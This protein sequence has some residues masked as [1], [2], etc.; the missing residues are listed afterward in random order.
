[1]RLTNGKIRLLSLLAVSLSLGLAYAQN[2]GDTKHDTGDSGKKGDD[3]YALVVGISNYRQGDKTEWIDLHGAEDA[4]AMQAALQKRGFLPSH[5]CMLV[6]E[7]ATRSKIEQSFRDCLIRRAHKDATLVFYFSG[8]GDQLLD[9]NG[10]EADGL[11]EALVPYD[12]NATPD[13]KNFLR[14]DR[15]AALL[16]EARRQM[17]NERGELQGDIAVFLDSCFAGSATRGGKDSPIIYRGRVPSSALPQTTAVG[18]VAKSSTDVLPGDDNSAQIVVLS[19]AQSSESAVEMR[20]EENK[21]QRGLFTYALTEALSRIRNPASGPLTYRA[22]FEE[23][24]AHVTQT[25]PA[26]HPQ[27]EGSPQAISRALFSQKVVYEG[28]Y[29]P[30]LSIDAATRTAVLPV[31]TLHGATLGSHYALFPAGKVVAAV[32]TCAKQAG[33]VGEATLSAVGAAR[34]TAQLTGDA[35]LADLVAG[36]AVEI[37]HSHPAVPALKVWLTPGAQV[38]AGLFSADPQAVVVL[39]SEADHDVRIEVREGALWAIKTGAPMAQLRTRAALADADTV[40]YRKPLPTAA[41]SRAPLPVALFGELDEALRAHWAYR[42]LSALSQSDDTLSVA[43]QLVRVQTPLQTKAAPDARPFDLNEEVAIEAQNQSPNPVYISIIELTPQ[44]DINVLYPDT[45]RQRGITN[46]TLP[47]GG[48]WKRLDARIRLNPPGQLLWKV[49]ITQQPADFSVIAHQRVLKGQSP[50][51]ALSKLPVAVQPLGQLI[52]NA[53]LR[54]R[55]QNVWSAPDSWA[56][57]DY[58]VSVAGAAPAVKKTP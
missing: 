39:G 55:S 37:L 15:L 24:R 21:P 12:W 48:T 3:Q 28:R 11:D 16:E 27:L 4:V 40:L 33:C 25:F 18:P 41:G 49:L 19:A 43:L 46:N 34:S 8:H 32:T 42:H 52:L 30:I 53:A 50:T 1:M 20:L 2:S 57:Q 54:L 5:I 58:V 26:Q 45:N 35:P 56:T 6:N 44:G 29:I 22:L 51:Q 38:A 14:D 23:V 10:D 36:R 9:E 7:Q 31:G 17:Q 47:A 13:H